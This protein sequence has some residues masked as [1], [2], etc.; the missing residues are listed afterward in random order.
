MRIQNAISRGE[1]GEGGPKFRFSCYLSH[2]ILQ[3][4]PFRWWSD[5]GRF[6][7]SGPCP[8]FGTYTIIQF[9]RSLKYFLC[10][11]VAV[12]PLFIGATFVCVVFEFGPC[13]VMPF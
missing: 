9:K 10:W 5:D 1:R 4:G 11:R 3:R 12:D 2:H 8:P 13:F 7:R 6:S